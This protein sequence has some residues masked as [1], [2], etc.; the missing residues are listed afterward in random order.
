MLK[1][2]LNPRARELPWRFKFFVF[3]YFMSVRN[4]KNVQT[5]NGKKILS[6]Y[7]PPF[8]SKA[9][10]TFLGAQVKAS[11][12]KPI[13]EIV[14]I[15]LTTGCENGCWHCTTSG[16]EEKLEKDVLLEVI[17]DLKELGTFQFLFTGGNPLLVDYLEELVK[18]ASGSSIALVS[19]PGPVTVERARALKKSGCQGVLVALEHHHEK[20]NDEIM[21]LKGAYKVSLKSIKNIAEA[22]MLTGTW[23][24]VSSDRI[25][26]LDSYLKFVKKKGVTDVA[27]FEPILSDRK[28]LLRGEDREYLL[29]IQKLSKRE[30]GYPR[31]ISGPFMDS[32]EF[33]GCTAGYN[34]M[35][36]A[37]SGDVYPCDMLQESQGNIYREK[38]RDIWKRMNRRYPEPLCGCLALD[39]TENKLP[40]YYRCLIRG[41]KT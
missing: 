37:S 11:R 22:G 3:K 15:S 4:R 24:V 17:K 16:E 34:R 10:D 18:A 23:I 5:L 19:T 12:G 31:V 29:N 2:L 6:I 8:P 32:S 9:F 13:P 25:S 1:L 35:H 20:K 36:I 39:N 33:M 14:N 27:I 30:S 40:D 26:Q 7:L 21:C 38:I 41:P 28:H